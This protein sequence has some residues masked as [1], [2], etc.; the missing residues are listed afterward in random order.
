MKANYETNKLYFF[1]ELTHVLQTRKVNN[2]EE[3]SFYDGKTGMFLTEGAT[4]LTAEILYHVSNG[5]NISYKEQPNSVRGQ[6]NHVPYS[7]LSEYQLNGN[8]LMLLSNSLGIPL[9]QMLALGYKKEGRKHLK[10]LY[11]AFPGN[12][13]KFEEFMFELE[14]IYS[15]DKLLLYGYGNQLEGE[16]RKITMQNGQE[17]EG[18]LKRQEK[19]INNIEREL[20]A[21][22][23]ANNEPDYIVA[24]YQKISTYLTVPEFKKN[25]MKTVKEVSMMRNNQDDGRSR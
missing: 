20:A 1:H 23:I 9:N 24:N 18:N 14:K 3:C 17:F 21:S 5:T 11:E 15:I 8:I 13:G 10:E 25:F 22:F 19:I 12:E 6:K 2:Y 16:P 4:Q 7:P